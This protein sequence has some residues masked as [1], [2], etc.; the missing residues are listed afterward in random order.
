MSTRRLKALAAICAVLISSVPVVGVP[1]AEP[2]RVTE[3]APGV[4]VHEGLV[5]LAAPANAGAIANSGFIIGRDAVAVI[6][7]EGSRAAGEGLLAA[8]RQRTALPIRYVIN[9]HVHP[10]HVLGNAAFKGA[11]TTFV[12]HAQLPA[13]L[14]AR[15]AVY[16]MANRALIGLS[17]DGTEVV[18]PTLLV[19]RTLDL[20]LGDRLL[21]IEAWPTAHTNTDVTVYD[22]TTDTWFLGD[23]L[24]ANHVPALDGRLIGWRK[25][26]QTL[27]T[28]TAARVVPGHGPASMPWPAAA[29]PT[30]RYLT[31]LE[32]DLR[33]MVREGRTLREAAGAAARSEA[34]NWSLF[35]EFNARNATTAFQELEWSE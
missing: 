2:L 11:G 20:D 6:D 28:R 8:V 17:F 1:A 33:V 5:A 14:A 30:E 16:L 24:F 18:Q 35:D 15:E 22:L 32:S 12:G 13:A 31:Q 3:I 9:T 23:L 4:F 7:T 27:R 21:R 10:D 25:T 29:E 19:D 34:R 26:L